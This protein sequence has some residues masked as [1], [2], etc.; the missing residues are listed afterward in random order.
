MQHFFGAW[1]RL[2][3]ML[4]D[5]PTFTWQVNK[6]LKVCLYLIFGFTLPKRE[7]FMV[8]STCSRLAT[9]FALI[10]D[11]LGFKV[12]CVE[13][14]LLWFLCKQT[15]SKI[16]RLF[17]MPLGS[18]QKIDN[19]WAHMPLVWGGFG[20]C[21]LGPPSSRCM[22]CQ[23]VSPTS[24]SLSKYGLCCLSFLM[25]GGYGWRSKG[26]KGHHWMAPKEVMPIRP[27]CKTPYFTC[28]TIHPHLG[29]VFCLAL[30]CKAFWRVGSSLCR[31]SPLP[32]N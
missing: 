23:E 19:L 26:P 12:D 18:L 29:R 21:S 9:Y 3:F 20:L 31:P 17:Y 25:Q 15:M 30:C 1:F 16:E 11:V 27:I 7:P 32:N 13:E 8:A 28:C 5:E 10:L 24:F 6:Q 22:A 14:Y 2:V 4:G